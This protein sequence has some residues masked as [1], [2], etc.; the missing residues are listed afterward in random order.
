MLALPGQPCTFTLLSH[1]RGEEA[2]GP[3]S[4]NPALTCLLPSQMLTLFA[5][6]LPSI[7]SPDL[8]NHGVWF[9]ARWTEM[10][11]SPVTVVMLRSNSQV[12]WGRR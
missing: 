10:F 7:L 4:A 5:I 9:K 11:F 6:T 3:F 8:D 1:N 2:Y 12:H